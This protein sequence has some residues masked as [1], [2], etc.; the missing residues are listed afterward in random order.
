[1]LICTVLLKSN[2]ATL[3]AERSVCYPGNTTLQHAVRPTQVTHPKHTH[4]HTRAHTH[5]HTQPQSHTHSHT[6]THTHSHTHTHT[7]TRTH[8]HTHTHAPTHTHSLSLSHTH[9]HTFTQTDLLSKTSHPF[10]Q[11]DMAVVEE[12]KA[13]NSVDPVH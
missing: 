3:G 5:T 8:N 13:P 11:P 1:M 12:I 7:H 4:T 10:Q 2:S 6:T 9:A